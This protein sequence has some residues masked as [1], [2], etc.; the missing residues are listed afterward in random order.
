VKVANPHL[1]LGDTVRTS[2][3]VGI[4]PPPNGY[5]RVAMYGRLRCQHTMPDNVPKRPRVDPEPGSRAQIKT[6]TEVCIDD[7]LDALGLSRL[8]RSRRPLELLIRVPG[9]RLARQ[10]ATYDEI[11]GEF[12]LSA[13]GEWALER[14]TRGLKVEGRERVPRDGSLLLVSNHPGLSDAVALFASTPRPDLC[15]MASEWPLLDVLPNTS[16]HLFTIAENPASRLGAVRAAA[17]HLRGGGALLLFPAGRME[18][19]PA[20]MPGAVEVLG[21]W[22]ANVDLFARLAPNLTVVPVVVSGVLSPAAFGNPL[23]R[24][25]RPEGDRRWLAS[26]LQMLVPALRNVSPRVTFGLPIRDSAGGPISTVVLPEVRR[27]ME[28]YTEDRKRTHNPSHAR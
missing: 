12:G 9:R 20:V 22:S 18:P 4:V 2:F 21:R 24:L 6:L 8:S 1:V 16:R 10:I 26:N 19:D 27:L 3:V 17:R 13:G 25:R 23:T 15:V 5:E 28:R 7:L 11:V 14:M